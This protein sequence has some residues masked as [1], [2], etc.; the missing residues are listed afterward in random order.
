MTTEN[1]G[2]KITIQYPHLLSS[3]KRVLKQNVMNIR[4][5]N[6]LIIL[7]KLVFSNKIIIEYQ[8]KFSLLNKV[9]KI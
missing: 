7:L 9:Y 8:I 4:R 2:T 1:C 3:G 6:F 5:L